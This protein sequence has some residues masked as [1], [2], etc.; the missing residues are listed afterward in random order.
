MIDQ[1]TVAPQTNA[2]AAAW[3]NGYGVIRH[4]AQTQSRIAT[5]ASRASSDRTEGDGVSIYKL[6]SLLDRLT[7][8]AL[9]LVVHETYARKV[10]LD[11][12]P[13]SRDEFKPKPDGHTGGSLN[14]VP[15]Y[16]GYLAANV[17]SAHT[18]GWLMGQGHCVA[19]VDSLNLL[20]GNLLA[21]HSERYSVSDEGLTRYVQDFYSYRLNDSGVQDSPLGSH[22]NHNTAGGLAGC[23]HHDQQRSPDRP[24]D[25]HV[26]ARWRGLVLPSSGAE[27][28]RSYRV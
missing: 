10:H 23:S 19:A 6:L 14:V 12:R 13:L 15:A 4:T 22:V 27:R 28:V 26:A 20:V 9:W 2:E 1:E 17:L 18:R 11:G 8:A 3:A 25:D 16:A 5:L 7:S 24:A 21:A